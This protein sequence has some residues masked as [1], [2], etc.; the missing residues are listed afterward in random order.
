MEPKTYEKDWYWYNITHKD[1]NLSKSIL[2]VDMPNRRLIG[3]VRNI[4]HRT[5][6]A[7]YFHKNRPDPEEWKDWQTLVAAARLAEDVPGEQDMLIGIVRAGIRR[8]K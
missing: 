6:L 4:F 5:Y 1:K 8:N 7:R 3:L 2:P